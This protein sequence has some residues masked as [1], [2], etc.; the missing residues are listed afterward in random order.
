MSSTAGKDWTPGEMLAVAAASRI[1]DGDVAVVGLGPPQVAALLARRTH[2]PTLQ[3]LLE[4]GVFDARPTG[5]SMGIADPRMWEGASVF[6]GVLDVLGSMLQG[7]RVSLGILSAVQVDPF[8]SINTTQVALENGA[9]RRINGSGGGNDIASLSGRVLVVLRHEPRRFRSCLDFLTSPGRFVDGRRRSELGLP[10]YGT[11]AVVSDRAIIE[12][13]DE[14]ALLSSV[15]PGESV[16]E[17]LADTPFPLRTPP[18]GPEVTEAP[19]PAQLD[20]LRS[21][22]DPLQWYTS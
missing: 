7:G 15:H 20:V 6:G 11:A 22:I 12:I 10:G 1:K 18:G 13:D 16:E 8:G 2:A 9:I 14:G 21:E 19:T 4:I 3:I 5:P 17:V